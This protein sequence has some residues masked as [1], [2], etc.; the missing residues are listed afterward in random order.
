[1]KRRSTIVLSTLAASLMAF[2]GGLAPASA[3]PAPIGSAS[4][5]VDSSDIA[6]KAGAY[7][8]RLVGGQVPA[9][10]GMTAFSVIACSTKTDIERHNEVAAVNL[11][12]AGTISGVA[13]RNWTVKTK[14]GAMHSYSRS[15]TAEVVLADSPLGSLSIRGVTSLSHA[16]YDAKGFHTET[17]TSIGK[18]LLTPPV[19][20]PQEIDIPAPGQPITIPGLATLY[21]GQT[22]ETSN[23]SAAR[24][25]ATAL[26]VKIIPTGTDLF[27]ARSKAQALNGV[28]NGRFGGYSAGTEAEVL[29]G[30]LTSGRNPLSIMPCQSTKGEVLS[31]A[32]ARLDLGGG[33]VVDGV[34]S[35]QWSKRFDNRSKA[36]ER[37]AVA[38]V[39]LGNGA[40]V[41]D[42]LV[43]KATVTRKANGGLER[44]T[45]GTTIGTITANGQPQDLP[46]DQTIEIPGLAK[47]EPKVVEKLP[48]GLKV[49]ALRITL[50]DGTGAVIDLGIAKTTI[51]R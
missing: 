39:N 36:W 19:G 17:S 11:P 13:T 51:R 46:I 16:W 45:K 4:A 37:G 24:A 49:I 2:S 12:G 3:A 44:S 50:L 27:V 25:W 22:H 47:L 26:R 43:A 18:I 1:M 28:K 15:S 8:T 35:S 38:G 42:A 30:V 5:R 29:G 14:S 40:L 7:G 6:L 10:S 20:D 32:D 33:L 9:G 41:I 31:R 23:S 21:L 34:S 48:G